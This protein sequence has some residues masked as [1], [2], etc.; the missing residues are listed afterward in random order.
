MK[1]RLS[2]WIMGLLNYAIEYRQFYSIQ[3]LIDDCLDKGNAELTGELHCSDGDFVFT[4][5]LY[6]K[7]LKNEPINKKEG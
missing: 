6:Q 4:M 5:E 3:N 7:G 1:E 2:S